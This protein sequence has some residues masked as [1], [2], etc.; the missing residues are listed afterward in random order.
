MKSTLH[1]FYFLLLLLFVPCAV[2]AQE[3][4][5]ESL[6]FGA[7]YTGD[8]VT[9]I[10]GGI[11]TGTAYLGMATIDA[12]FDTE[13]AKWWKGGD[14]FVKLANTHG[15]EPTAHLVG[16]FQGVS[17]I[18]AGNLTWL[19]EFWYR[20]CFGN[21]SVTV[22]LQDL[23]V[24]FAADEC[25]AGFTNSSFGIHS[26]IADNIPSPIFPL[27][28]LGVNL[29]WDIS[30]SMVLK[31]AVFDGTP[32][33]LENNPYNIH[34]QLSREQGVL[35][36]GELQLNRSLFANKRGNYKIGGY[37]HQHNDST[38]EEQQNGGIYFAGNQQITDKI[39][40]FSQIGLS[41]K[42][43][44]HN[45]YYSIGLKYSDIFKNRP[46]DYMGM[47]VAYAGIDSNPN[48]GET[49][50]EIIYQ[51]QICSN[52]YIRPDIQYIV[53]PAGTDQKLGNALVAMM[54]FGVEF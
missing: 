1:S 53:N 24:N 34:W 40:V 21:L 26:S 37:F 50:I 16:D 6:Y 44:N 3:K 43:N 45:H 13:K 52:V 11:K 25:A 33:D 31:M 17:N 23:N 20:Q 47:A 35:T 41:P 2:D 29:N 9:N 5:N 38:N 30:P 7:T 15:G 8:L 42:R 54:R 10:K 27:T 12:G 19:Y 18:E 51:C 32:D 36:V 46:D 14:A 39:D 48:G 28:A 4:T 22:G 49:V